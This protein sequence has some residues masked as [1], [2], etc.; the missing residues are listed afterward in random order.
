MLDAASRKGRRF[1]LKVQ[2]LRAKKK[3][4]AEN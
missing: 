4:R 2:S 1:E 3:L